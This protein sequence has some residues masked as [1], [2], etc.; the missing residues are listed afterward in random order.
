MLYFPPLGILFSPFPIH[1]VLCS[2]HKQIH[3]LE[4][5]NNLI[6]LTSLFM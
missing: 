6:C 5:L 2:T 3:V 1:A 4:Y